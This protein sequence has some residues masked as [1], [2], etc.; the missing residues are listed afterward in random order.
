MVYQCSFFLALNSSNIQFI[1]AR[2]YSMK[3]TVAQTRL[4]RKALVEE[5]IELAFEL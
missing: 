4:Q 5:G 1:G 3:R 2:R